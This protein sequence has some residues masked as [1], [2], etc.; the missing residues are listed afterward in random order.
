MVALKALSAEQHAF[1]SS[2]GY[3][4]YDDRPVISE[5]L[6]QALRQVP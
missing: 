6:L 1:F 2:Q 5:S 3:L 4:A